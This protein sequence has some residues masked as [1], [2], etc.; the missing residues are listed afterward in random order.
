MEKSE[1]KL[2]QEEQE[3]LDSVISQMDEALKR[4]LSR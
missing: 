3:I 4:C 2:I 1:K